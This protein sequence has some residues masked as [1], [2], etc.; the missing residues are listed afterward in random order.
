MIHQEEDP[1]ET[2]EDVHPESI[3]T[4]IKLV[5]NVAGIFAPENALLT[6]PVQCRVKRLAKKA[7][8]CLL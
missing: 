4:D 8:L 3:E 5:H 6:R 2:G 7:A 1:K